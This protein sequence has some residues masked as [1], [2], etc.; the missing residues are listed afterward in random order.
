MLKK[1]LKDLT[2][3]NGLPSQEDRII[4]YMYEKFTMDNENV[5]VDRLGNI[6]SFFKSKRSNAKKLVVF[7]HMDEIG[8]IIRKIEKKGFLRFERIGGVNTQILP[9][10]YVNV[11]GKTELF[12]IIGVQSHHFMNPENKFK[13]PQIKDLYIDI[14]ANS[15]DDVIRLGVNVGDMIA[16]KHNWM[17]MPNSR[18]STKAIDNRVGCSVLLSL[19]NMIRDNDL[20][21]DVYLVA[22]VME[23]FNIRGILPAIKV[24]NPDITIGIDVTPACDTPDMDYNDLELSGGLALTYMNFHGRGTLAG[25]LP[26]KKLLKE[27]ES[28]CDKNDIKYQNEIST[29]VITEN[30]YILLENQGI[31]VANISIPTRYTHTPFECVDMNDVIDAVKIIYLFITQTDVNI[32]YGK[33]WRNGKL[34]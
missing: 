32:N 8:F 19:S 7:A 13:V 27:L 26:D 24:I 10:S 3:L 29:G 30:A 12:G 5:R 22:S 6:T 21:F 4:D 33:D 17:E 23:E 15:F 2:E 11:L 20:N 31:A 34:S 9:G 25:V 1:Y 16:F 14:G 28:V 18:I